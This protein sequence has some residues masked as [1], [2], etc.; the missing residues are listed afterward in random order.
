MFGKPQWF[1]PKTVRWGIHPIAWQGW[2]YSLTWMGVIAAPFLALLVRH[3]AGESLVWLTASLFALAWDV[4]SIRKALQ[5][6]ADRAVLY[7]GED[8]AT[9]HLVS[10][11]CQPQAGK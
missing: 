5:P 11:Q 4:R 8:G 2:A 3:Q 1:R 7:I 9:E 10:Q 6:Q